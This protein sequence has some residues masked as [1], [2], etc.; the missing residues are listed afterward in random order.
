VGEDRDVP[1]LAMQFLEGKSLEARLVQERKLPV[2]EVLRIGREVALA[3]AAAHQR[4]LIHRDIK[5]ANIWLEAG[6]KRAKVLDFGLARV[7]REGGQLTEPG[8]IIGTP[9]Y[10]APEQAQGKVLDGRCDLFSLGC[11]LYR[12]ATGQPAFRGTD[13][14]STLAALVTKTP[15]PPRELE[16][17]LPPALSGLIV[18]LL[19][20]EPDRRPS[21]AETVAR[22]LE[23]IAHTTSRH[24]GDAKTAGWK[25]A[26]GAAVA[27]GVLVVGLLILWAA[28]VFKV[29]V[30]EGT[31]VVQVS[32]PGAEVFV[33]GAKVTVTWG[34]GGKTAE[35]RVRPGTRKVEIRKE[36]F[37]AHGEEVTLDEGGNR[38]ITAHLEPAKAPTPKPFTPA[39]EVVRHEYDALAT[40]RWA[41]VLPG[42]EDFDRLLARKE[43]RMSEPRF[44]RGLLEVHGWVFFPSFKAKDAIIRGKMKKL[45]RKGVGNVGMAL[46]YSEGPQFVTAWCNGDGWFG[47]GRRVKGEPWKDLAA[48]KLPDIY[49]DFFE[50]SLAVVGDSLTA[51]IDGR[52]IVEVHDPVLA[53]AR[54]HC[55]VGGEGQFRDIEVQVLDKPVPRRAGRIAPSAELEGLRRD[56]IS[57]E[58]LALAGNG[59]PNRAPASLVAV[60]GEPV[61]IQTQKICLAFSPDGR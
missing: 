43:Y 35:V 53:E 46:R 30:P 33:D 48:C 4:G 29:K 22:A 26:I 6:T 16:P 31:L 27:A 19:T 45:G 61:P 25:W 28:G 37:A 57:S 21:S 59:D 32:E 56:T 36:G 44:D 47:I 10:M 20:K 52:R 23:S 41:L 50:F 8:A 5:P 13:I 18:A 14:L 15:P 11:V 51:Y 60:L 9:A 58:A 24:D 42:K 2:A 55:A 34:E 39:P 54:G 49:D 1:F 17:S 12:M 3:L 7:A 40:G 38:L